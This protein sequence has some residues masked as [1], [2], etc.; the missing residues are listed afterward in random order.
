M[1]TS[2][3]GNKDCLLILD[4]TCQT[5]NK[6]MQRDELIMQFHFK[7]DWVALSLRMLCETWSEIKKEN[8]FE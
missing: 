2:P 5:G 8:Y 7:C 3:G 1:Y 6:K 4:I